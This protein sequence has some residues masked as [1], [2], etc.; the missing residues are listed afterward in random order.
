MTLQPTR[1][2]WIDNTRTA[3]V[4]LVVNM[5]CCVT[6]SYVGGWYLNDGPERSL[7]WKLPYIFWVFHLQAFF[8]GLLFF[9]A[10]AFADGAIQRHGHGAFLKE[11]TVRLGLPAML[12]ML[13]LQP[14]ILF[15]LLA[16]DTARGDP[17]GVAVV[18][19]YLTSKRM[20]AGSGPMWFALALLFFSAVLVGWRALFPAAPLSKPRPAP[21]ASAL[22]A[23]ALL[24]A[25][26]TAAT[27]IYFPIETSFFNFQLCYFPQYIAAFTVGLAAGR[28]GW[29]QALAAS[30]RAQIAGWMG[31][32]GG[33]LALALLIYL[34]GAPAE[35]GPKSYF[36]GTNPQAFGAAIW[37]QFAGLGLA[38][39]MMA[40]FQRRVD[41]ASALA[42]W[43]SARS[44]GVYVLHPPVII[45]LTLVFRPLP[46]TPFLHIVLLTGTGLAASFAVADLAKRIPGLRRIL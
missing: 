5:H 25:L 12:Y 44:F 1:S 45:A 19:D 35:H 15:G 37:E 17:H 28:G 18:I 34:G 8:M 43:L 14:L 39:G 46:L 29:L 9:L 38:L 40:W 32:I 31:L 11:R 20:L 42:S 21:G 41:R 4:I 6:Y 13:V 30:R 10:G 33:P 36:G 22:W 2:T 16:D 27:R 26:S 7:V 24:L 23:F 3:V